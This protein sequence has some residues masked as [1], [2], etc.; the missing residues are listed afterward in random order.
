MTLIY[1]AESEICKR[2][3]LHMNYYEILYGIYAQVYFILLYI[4]AYK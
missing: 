2:N 4:M 3:T 1:L